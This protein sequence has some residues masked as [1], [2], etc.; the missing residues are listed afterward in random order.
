MDKSVT[1]AIKTVTVSIELDCGLLTMPR[2]KCNVLYG[3]PA[4]PGMLHEGSTRSPL[5]NTDLHSV[6]TN[7]SGFY[8]EPSPIC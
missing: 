8:P 5:A 1:V 2:C 3:T 4:I 7:Y 6:L